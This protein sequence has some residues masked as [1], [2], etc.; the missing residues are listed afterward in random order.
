MSL[1]LPNLP[2][3]FYSKSLN[4][5][6]F[7][8]RIFLDPFVIF[9]IAKLGENKKED[10]IFQFIVRYNNKKCRLSSC[11]FLHLGYSRYCISYHRGTYQEYEIHY[12]LA[13]L[14]TILIAAYSA[15]PTRIQTKEPTYLKYY[16]TR[17][18]LKRIELQKYE[19][20]TLVKIFYS[21]SIFYGRLYLKLF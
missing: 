2:R 4:Q 13:T 6:T 7:T 14:S 3:K 21:L 17:S 15:W 1:T 18:L 16:F 20:M 8:Q 9:K 19:H 10:S 12:I 11:F 5:N